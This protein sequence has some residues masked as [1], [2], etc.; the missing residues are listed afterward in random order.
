[1]P[2]LQIQ[3]LGNFHL[4]SNGEPLNAL[5][6]GR[7]QS[8]LAYLI[9]HRAAPQSR[10]HLAF[11]F[12]PDSLEAQ[13][14][15]NL[16]QIL[17]HLRQALPDAEH[18]LQINTKTVQW[19]PNGPFLLDVAKFERHIEQAD[20]AAQGGDDASARAALQT[21][22]EY[23]RGDLLLGCYDEWILPEREHWQKAF[24][25]ALE[26]LVLL[27]E[28]QRDY[29][30]AVDYAQ[31]L[32][33]YDPLHE[34][35]YRHLMRL[36]ALTGDRASALR[37]YHT[38]ATILQREL[39]VE[40]SLKTRSAYEHLLNLEASLELPSVHD[41]QHV[42]C[43]AQDGEQLIG[44][45]TEWQKLQTA[46]RS[47]VNRRARFLV[48]V[49]EAGIGKT[50]LAE[51]LSTWVS[52]QGIR[53]AHTRAYAAEGALAYAPVA[54]WLRTDTLRASWHGL[55]VVWLTELA[56]ILP[57]L[58]V[59]QPHLTRPE[60]L[61][62]SWQ[63]KRLFEAL[64]RAVLT[65]NRPLLLVL[66][67]LQWC[68]RETL[69][70]LHYL[71]RYAPHA[72][73]LIIGTV[74]PEEVTSDHP[75]TTLLLDLR[76]TEQLTELELGPLSMDETTALAMQVA[77]QHL[78]P[79][80]ARRLYGETEGNPLFVVESMRA[81]LSRGKEEAGSSPRLPDSPTLLPAKI[82]AVIHRRLA[83]LSPTARELAN[84]ASVIGRSFTFPVLRQAS[85]LAED[86][87]M[88]GLDELWQRRIV[89]ELGADAYD[90]SHDRI[91]EVTQAAISQAQRRLLHRRAAQALEQVH[92][93]DLEPVIGQI[94]AHYERAGMAEPA[95]SSYLR[96]AEVARQLYANQ[97]A[98]SYFTSGLELL[99]SLPDPILPRSPGNR[100]ADRPGKC[101]HCCGG[102]GFSRCPS[103]FCPRSGSV[104]AD[105]G[106]AGPAFPGPV[107]IVVVLCQ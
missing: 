106:D 63:R 43:S 70:W 20:A 12:W 17:H 95:I 8:L 62:E 37:V 42:T 14:R 41:A 64:G 21:A 52:R 28:V 30:A 66:D 100:A 97:D 82:H 77:G 65:D 57:E 61:S 40:P 68:D 46:W 51:E 92:A 53:T 25:K 79:D 69:E 58:L 75:L 72:Q 86:V 50:R 89:R 11:L 80:V 99:K 55:D 6:Q 59:E 93:S 60:P 39:G 24:I 5:N 33:R 31:R 90:F 76:S 56:R 101:P 35:T 18:F 16:R 91:R 27:A 96:A 74:R 4:L 13:A 103:G 45:Q 81:E 19:L 84:L 10:Q 23:Y 87:L 85:D 44:R 3:L 29:G 2:R 67:D 105:G 38:C 54:E 94:A 83:Q 73:L 49:G 36:H 1:M 7:L 15:A 48:V 26:Q 32:L 102:Y 9:L 47:A 34:T 22:V 98:I 107:G 71:L 78:A 88:R 104:P